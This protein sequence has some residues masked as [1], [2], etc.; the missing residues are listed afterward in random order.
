MPDSYVANFFFPFR[1]F[2][3]GSV[4]LFCILF[5][6]FWVSFCLIFWDIRHS[7][8]VGDSILD[9]FVFPFGDSVFLFGIFVSQSRLTLGYHFPFW[10]CVFLCGVSG[11]CFRVLFFVF[12]PFCYYIYVL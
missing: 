7:G 11:L 1:V 3:L 9:L 10:L 6:F 12:V 2:V 4:I 8:L 5:S